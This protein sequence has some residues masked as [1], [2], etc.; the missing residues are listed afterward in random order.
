MKVTVR[1][2]PPQ[3]TLSVR[4]R[5]SMTNLSQSIG[6]FLG[7]VMGHTTKAGV[8]PAGMP[9]TRLHAVEGDEVEL[10]A[11]IPIGAAASGEGRVEGG[12][13]PGGLVASFDYFG[14]YDGLTGARDALRAWARDNGYV[15]TGPP[16]EIYWTDP[17][18]EPDPQKWR[19]EILLPVR[20]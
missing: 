16:W 12:A 8:P 18:A 2:A 3:P 1:N 13:L 14:P 11:G 5:A 7:E 9:Y 20:K 19:T 15:E 6:G 4:G 10:E 17:G